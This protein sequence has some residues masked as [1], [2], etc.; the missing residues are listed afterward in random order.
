MSAVWRPLGVWPY[1]PQPK[2][3]AKFRTDWDDSLAKLETEIGRTGGRDVVIGI[4][5]DEDQI[6][7][8]GTLRARAK[9]HHPGAEVSF[10]V[11]GRGR[12]TFHTDVYP[13]LHSNLHAIASGL[14]ALRAVERHGISQSGQQYAGFMQLPASVAVERGRYLVAKAGSVK[15]ALKA[16]HPDQ[17]G[18][19]D[20]L[21][22]VQ[23]YREVHGDT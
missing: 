20:D 11:P 21:Q 7:Y 13:N 9:V 17:G 18:T 1:P 5:V 4:V 23:A 19:S 3:A 2:L 8:S 12:L 10:D 6:S 15:A 14:E 22:A 16:H